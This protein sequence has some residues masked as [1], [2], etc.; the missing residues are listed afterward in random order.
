MELSNQSKLQ[1][2][3]NALCRATLNDKSNSSPLEKN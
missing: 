2:V 3:D 1:V